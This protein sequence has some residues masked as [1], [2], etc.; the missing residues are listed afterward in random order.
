MAKIDVS[1]L[2]MLEDRIL[3]RKDKTEK[4]LGTGEIKVLTVET[5]NYGSVKYGV[6]VN[7]GP[8]YYG[9]DSQLIPTEV[10]VGDTIVYTDGVPTEI[11]GETF[12]LLRKGDVLGVV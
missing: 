3:V 1:K 5:A 2:K 12:D 9:K 10:K 6:V 11:E 8:G 7:S 4:S